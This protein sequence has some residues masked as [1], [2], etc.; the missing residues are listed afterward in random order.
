MTSFIYFVFAPQ[1]DI[2]VQ[3]LAI[4]FE[5]SLRCGGNGLAPFAP[6]NF[7]HG[8]VTLEKRF[9]ELSENCRRHM[10][11]KWAEDIPDSMLDLFR[12]PSWFHKKR[13]HLQDEPEKQQG[14]A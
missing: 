1:P 11:K 2:T 13:R 10:Q 5:F 6:P 7:I 14:D 9:D 12:W 4:L 3:E 8:N